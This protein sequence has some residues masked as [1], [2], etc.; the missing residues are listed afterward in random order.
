MGFRVAPKTLE[1]LEWA[2]IVARLAARTRT[3]RARARLDPAAGDAVSLFESDAEGVRAR[4]AETGEARALLAAGIGLPAGDLPDPAEALGRARRGGALDPRALLDLRGVL[5]AVEE[6]RRVLPARKDAAP[7]LAD[8]AECL[9]EHGALAHAIGRSLDPSGEVRDEASPRL[10]EARREARRLAGAIETRLAQ[11][12]RDPELRRHLSDTYSTVRNDRYVLPVRS[13][14][15]GSVPGIVH[16]ASRSG[17]TL[18]IEPEALVLLNNRHKQVALEVI[19]ETQRVLRELSERAAASA[20]AIDADLET[21]AHLDLAFARAALA[22]EMQAVVPEVGEAGVLRLPGLRHPLIPPGEV[23]AND[24]SLGEGWQI[25]VLSGPNAGGKTVAMKAVA[26]AALL[27]RAGLFVPAAPGARIDLFDEVLAQIGDEQDIREHLSTFSAQMANLARIV[28]EASERSLVALD[29]VGVGT[30]PGEGAALAQ[31]VLEALA[32]AG[33]RVVATTHYGLLKEMAEVDPRFANA[34]VELDPE[35]LAPTYRLRMGLP[36]VSSA[37]S[38]AAR[39]GMPGAVLAR[40]NQILDREDRQLDRMLAELSASRATLESEQR[41]ATRLRTES[42]AVRAEYRERVER[43]RTRRDELYHAMRRELD[44]AFRAAHEEVA[45]VIRELQRG[46]TARDAA[47]ARDRLLA[48]GEVPPAPP[49]SAAVE[50]EA[51]AAP[52]APEPVAAAPGPVDWHLAAAGDAVLLRDGGTALLLALPDRRG[53]VTIR[54]GSARVLVPAERVAA[55]RRA[56]PAAAPRVT[57]EVAAGRGAHDLV[58]GDSGRCDL[59]GLRVDEARDRLAADLDRALS[60]GRARLEIVHG[61]GTGALRR[62]VRE[63]LAAAPFVTRVLD[64]PPEQG[65]DGVTIAELG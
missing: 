59:R 42:E 13:D 19:Q 16:D 25:L 49:A 57:F 11:L 50:A 26:L 60:A 18:F 4:L 46:G 28:R 2:Q 17:M 21:L 36:G 52:L 1:R 41:E 27:V 15:V 39:M 3:P 24:L 37:T 65:G 8:L 5:L 62:A 23:V 45:S 29:E 9:G 63:E 56:A 43:L 38:V 33:A 34:S 54:V 31:A 48:L 40:A 10:A 47:R 6:T 44:H 7:R 20:S 61:I 30:D 14:A 53:R 51:E 58:A 64:A 55:L 35:T 12:V 32:T 22:E